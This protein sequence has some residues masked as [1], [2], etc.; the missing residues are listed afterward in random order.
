LILTVDDNPTV[1]ATAVLQLEALRDINAQIAATPS[2]SKK[3]DT[4]GN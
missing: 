1:L 3:N 4:C 2:V